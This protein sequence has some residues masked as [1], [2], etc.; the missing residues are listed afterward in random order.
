[1]KIVLIADQLTM[2][3]QYSI[4]SAVGSGVTAISCDV[5]EATLRTEN[6]GRVTLDADD[7]ARIMASLGP[8][9]EG[10]VVE[11]SKGM[12][13]FD[14]WYNAHRIAPDKD[15]GVTM[16]AALILARSAYDAGQLS[17]SEVP[18]NERIH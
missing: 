7:R 8:W 17:V 18:S 1:M 16:E 10:K 4:I 13:G 12:K 9:I 11:H 6:G 2:L 3:V 14:A 15:N 5:T